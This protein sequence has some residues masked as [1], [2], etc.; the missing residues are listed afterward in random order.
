MGL[1]WPRA[2]VLS[3]MAQT[4]TTASNQKV[5]RIAELPRYS[6]FRS[7][8]FFNS[9]RFQILP[10]LAKSN[11]GPNPPDRET[12]S[13]CNQA[14]K[15]RSGPGDQAT[16]TNKHDRSDPITNIAMSVFRSLMALNDG[17]CAA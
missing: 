11:P 10:N 1:S 14:S 7:M 4:A 2:A 5:L 9:F 17:S 3:S 8:P 13:Y 12:L 15:T 6:R 16:T